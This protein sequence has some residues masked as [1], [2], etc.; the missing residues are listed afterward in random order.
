MRVFV[1]WAASFPRQGDAGKL[2]RPVG[3]A[4]GDGP[5]SRSVAGLRGTEEARRRHEQQEGAM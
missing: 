1:L 3:Q 2:G 5:V 4:L